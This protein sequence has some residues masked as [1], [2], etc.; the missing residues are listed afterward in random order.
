[1]KKERPVLVRLPLFVV[2]VLLTVGIAAAGISFYSDQK[3]YLETEH[4]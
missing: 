3:A 1:V 4:A 2:F